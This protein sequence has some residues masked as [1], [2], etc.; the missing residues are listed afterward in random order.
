MEKSKKLSVLILTARDQWSDK[1]SGW[2]LVPMI[3]SLNPFKW[4]S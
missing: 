3:M 1:V 4:K 2:L